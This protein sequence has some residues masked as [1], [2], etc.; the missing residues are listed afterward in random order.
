MLLERISSYHG[1]AR[2][3]ELSSSFLV[4]DFFLIVC[5]YNDIFDSLACLL[6]H[7]YCSDD[8]RLMSRHHG[9]LPTCLILRQSNVHIA[10][11]K[12]R[13]YCIRGLIFVISN[14]CLTHNSLLNV[15]G[16]NELSRWLRLSNLRFLLLCYK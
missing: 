16:F 14:K 13:Y 6:V 5:I 2:S 3:L 10:L 11:L 9:Y 12:R 15:S 4:G 8:A 7:N 1:F